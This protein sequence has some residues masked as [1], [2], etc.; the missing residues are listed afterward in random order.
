MK[1]AQ[2]TRLLAKAETVFAEVWDCELT[3]AGVAYAAASSGGGYTTEAGSGGYLAQVDRVFRIQ[4][5]DLATEPEVG[6]L[7]AV[8]AENQQYR[9]VR[10]TRGGTHEAWRIECEAA[11]RSR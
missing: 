3:I 6:A 5:D 9:I 11:Q 10:V 2:F 7:V 8:E 4:K 1:K